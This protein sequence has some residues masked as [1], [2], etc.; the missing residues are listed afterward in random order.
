MGTH[1]IRQLKLIDPHIVRHL[2][3]WESYR[4][5]LIEKDLPKANG[6]LVEYIKYRI[7]SLDSLISDNSE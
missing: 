3:E 7:S 1:T 4:K 2:K 5:Q 6:V